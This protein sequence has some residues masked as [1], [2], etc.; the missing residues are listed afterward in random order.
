MGCLNFV[1]DNIVKTLQ[2]RKLSEDQME[3][4]LLLIKGCKDLLGELDEISQ[5][6]S[7]LCQKS[8][9]ISL[10]VQ[11]TWKKIT[12]NKETIE[13]YRNRFTSN[14]SLLDAFGKDIDRSVTA[15]DQI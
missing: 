2:E 6:F 11:K 5:K 12:W 8:T 13:Y 4:G 3:N 15:C 10:K 9:T 7:I 14:I 1:L